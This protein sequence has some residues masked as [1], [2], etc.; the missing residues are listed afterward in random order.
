M[1]N[2]IAAKVDENLLER[3]G[4]IGW[5]SRRDRMTRSF[6]AQ[7]SAVD[8]PPGGPSRMRRCRGQTP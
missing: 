8:S 2:V 4:A 1:P 6:Q 3:G 7:R 5:E